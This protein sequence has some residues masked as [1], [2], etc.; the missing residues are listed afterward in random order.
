MCTATL[1]SMMIVNFKR[2]FGEYLMALTCCGLDLTIILNS[3]LLDLV[4]QLIW[5]GG[6][7]GDLETEPKYAPPVSDSV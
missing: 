4:T 7:C 3:P 5:I 2:E 1:Q 6:L